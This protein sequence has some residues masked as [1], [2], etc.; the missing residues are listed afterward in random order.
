MC[1]DVRLTM[2]DLRLTITD[3]NSNARYETPSY[4]RFSSQK[5]RHQILGVLCCMLLMAGSAFAT[6]VAD[7][8]WEGEDLLI[9]F[10]DSVGYEVDL[11]AS[12]S[13]Q[14]VLRV[15]KAGL[16]RN[17]AAGGAVLTGPVGREAVITQSAPEELRITVRTTGAQQTAGQPAATR[18]GRL[19]YASLWRPYSHTLVVHTFDWNRLD[20]GQEQ[21]YKALLA[22]EQGLESHGLELLRIAYATGDSRAASVLGVYHA[23][24][25]EHGVAMQYLTKPLT[26]DDYTALAAAQIALGDSTAG[27]RNRQIAETMTARRDSAWA[28]SNVST[29][30]KEETPTNTLTERWDRLDASNR[31]LYL[32]GGI[33][34]LLLLILFVVRPRRRSSTQQNN[35]NDNRDTAPGPRPVQPSREPVEHTVVAREVSPPAEPY[36]EPEPRQEPPRKQETSPV[37]EHAPEPPVR[38]VTPVE[39]VQAQPEPR[40]IAKEEIIDVE[41]R[42]VTPEP[43]HGVSSQAAEL[44]KR[45]ESMRKA[46]EPEPP[47]PPKKAPVA[48]ESTMEE[49]R[50]LQLSR[51]SVE[52]RRRLQQEMGR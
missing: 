23:R 33:L 13:S 1:S 49:A 3:G 41:S 7:V 27:L 34:I 19:G 16:P 10:A 6:E 50:R 52:L 39:P 31:W 29:Q 14:L 17:A 20:Y 15:L 25:R 46:Q 42:P 5:L 45:I 9:R 18:A 47:P 30:K 28:T 51:D 36:R 48:S 43:A 44:R 38:E 12:D 4:L 11:A 22:L 21:Y 40:P 8:R 37:V 26:S 24:R 2:D 35:R 32:G